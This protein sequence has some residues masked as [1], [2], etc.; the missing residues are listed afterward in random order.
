MIIAIMSG[1]ALATTGLKNDTINNYTM[2]IPSTVSGAASFWDQREREP[3]GIERR[4]RTPLPSIP[5][6]SIT[7]AVREP[8]KCEIQDQRR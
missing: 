3:Q 2:T 6:T 5:K 4:G 8:C 1:R 7:E